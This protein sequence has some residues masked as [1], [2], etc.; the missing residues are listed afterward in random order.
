[1]VPSL[2]S[3]LQ[4]KLYPAGAKLA[5][6]LPTAEAELPEVPASVLS[7]LQPVNRKQKP[8]IKRKV[9]LAFIS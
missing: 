5:E 6:E 1:M 8:A 7:G 3:S 9:G 4:T 2:N